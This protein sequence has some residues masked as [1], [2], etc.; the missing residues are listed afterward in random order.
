MFVKTSVKTSVKTVSQ[1]IMAVVMGVSTLS[2]AQ[3]GEKS[4][5]GGDNAYYVESRSGTI[6]SNV[7]VDWKEHNSKG[8]DAYSGPLSEFDTNAVYYVPASPEGG[9][10]H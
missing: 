2:M 6:D 5:T 4:V 10:N 3:A 9:D 8:G 1:L 7:Q